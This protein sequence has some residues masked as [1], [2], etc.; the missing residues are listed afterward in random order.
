MPKTLIPPGPKAAKSLAEA[1]NTLAP[2]QSLQF[3]GPAGLGQDPSFYT[4]R[5]R[6]PFERI[7]L[8]SLTTQ[9][10]E[11]VLFTGHRGCGKSTE[12][13]RLAADL[14]ILRKFLVVKYS[15]FDVLDPNDVRFIDLL[16]SIAAQT[17]TR[18]LDAGVPLAESLVDRLNR[19][20]QTIR[21]PRSTKRKPRSRSKGSSRLFSSRPWV[22]SSEA[23]KARHRCARSWSPASPISWRSPTRSWT[24]CA[25]PSPAR[26]S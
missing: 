7:K 24:K 6:N 21:S 16:F 3:S 8:E 11:K 2:E 18:A 17:Y 26:T 14:D 4:D 23:W 1:M 19:W 15:V 22:G 12:L 20:R 13:N 10:R 25:W 9:A 5:D